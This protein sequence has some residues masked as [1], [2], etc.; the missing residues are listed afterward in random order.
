MRLFG[1]KNWELICEFM[2]YGRYFTLRATT[3]YVYYYYDHDKKIGLTHHV[4][5]LALFLWSVSLT[6]I[7][8]DKND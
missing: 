3:P 2:R 7:I 1:T 6:V 5:G 8:R 4:I